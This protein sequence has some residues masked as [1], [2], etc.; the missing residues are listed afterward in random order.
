[1]FLRNNDSVINNRHGPDGVIILDDSCMILSNRIGFLIFPQYLNYLMQKKQNRL[2][3][4]NGFSTLES[5]S[6]SFAFVSSAASQLSS[7]TD[8]SKC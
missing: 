8:V 7:S 4:G 5:M 1:M 2:V 6:V 3:L